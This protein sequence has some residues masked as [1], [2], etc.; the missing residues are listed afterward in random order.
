MPNFPKTARLR[1]SNDFKA[2]FSHGIKLVLPPIVLIA[3]R[4][5]VMDLSRQSRR[6]KGVEDFKPCPVRVGI[7]A[8]KKVGNAVVRNRCKR[9]L[10]ASLMEV[11]PQLVSF[12]R[13]SGDGPF[14]RAN[15][16]G[17]VDVVIVVR[18]FHL[19]GGLRD[20][21]RCLVEQFPRLL[22][23]LESKHRKDSLKIVANG[24]SDS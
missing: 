15:D 5:T 17:P 8:S 2:A 21:E 23:R 24:A 11:Y 12:L 10:R 20:I 19:L 6:P 13:G 1:H 3:S 16:R 14:D 7:V 22:S 18:S 4:P 9:L